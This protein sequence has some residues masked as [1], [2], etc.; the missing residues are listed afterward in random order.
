[1]YKKLTGQFSIFL[2]RQHEGVANAKKILLA[3]N[4]G[5]NL[6]YKILNI[7]NSHDTTEQ[8]M[9]SEDTIVK[10]ADKLWRYSEIGLLID[11]Q[12]FKSQPSPYLK[13][14]RTA[15]NSW[16]LTEEGKKITIHEIQWREKEALSK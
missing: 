3:L 15:D 14:L 12:R 10:D 2:N 6:I 13:Y 4:Y 16:F 11:I 9:P 7:I 5:K 1:L 8:A